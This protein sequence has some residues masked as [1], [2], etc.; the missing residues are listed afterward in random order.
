VVIKLA[1]ALRALNSVYYRGRMIFRS[2]LKRFLHDGEV[3]DPA[4]N[5]KAHKVDTQFLDFSSLIKAYGI[6]ISYINNII[7]IT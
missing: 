5:P 7:D 2:S 1:I 4:L 6:T 3:V